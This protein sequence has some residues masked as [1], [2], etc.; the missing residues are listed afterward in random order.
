M[1][2]GRDEIVRKR[3]DRGCM[4]V[5]GMV[6]RRARRNVVAGA[7]GEAADGSGPTVDCMEKHVPGAGD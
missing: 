3:E 5:G 7:A 1:R 2:R 6:R 4:M